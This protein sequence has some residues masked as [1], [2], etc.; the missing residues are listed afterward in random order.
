MNVGLGDARSQGIS[1]YGIDLVIPEYSSLSTKRVNS[2]L[3]IWQKRV[4]PLGAETGIFNT[5]NLLSAWVSVYVKSV[6]VH[7]HLNAPI[8]GLLQQ[9]CQSVHWASSTLLPHRGEDGT[10]L[11]IKTIFPGMGYENKMVLRPSYLYKVNFNI[12]MPWAMFHIKTFFPVIC[13]I[14]TGWHK[15]VL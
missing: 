14:K 10:H 13:I 9:G 5:L 6:W 12:R 7:P 11:N 8:P 4:N 1:S 2:F 15:I 3:P